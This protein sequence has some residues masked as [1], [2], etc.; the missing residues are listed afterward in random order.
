M[1]KQEL[2]RSVAGYDRYF[3]ILDASAVLFVL[4]ALSK[5]I[6]FGAVETLVEIAWGLTLI[7]LIWLGRRRDEFAEHCWREATS[8]TF[9]MLLAAPI[10]VSFLTGV[11]DGFTSE[12]A[13]DAGNAAAAARS[14]N[15]EPSLD[16][17]LI[18]LFATFFASFEWS[19][20]RGGAE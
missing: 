20:F 12:A 3:L 19:R 13:R 11:V 1:S 17:I 2:N 18:L 5:A 9:I 6:D 14:E 8:A 15:F 10:L 7:A 16:A 4:W